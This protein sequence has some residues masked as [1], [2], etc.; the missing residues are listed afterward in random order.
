MSVRSKTN[1]EGA[2]PVGAEQDETELPDGWCRTSL[3]AIGTI[4]CGQSPATKD[5]NANGE[6][7]PYVTGPEQWDGHVIH[8]NKWTT[9]PRRIV[10]D[11][12][13]FITVKGAGVGTLF[14]GEACAIGRDVYAFH[15]TSPISRDFTQYAL[16]YT[17]DLVIRQASGLIPGLSRSH[18]LEHGI[19]LPPLAEQR[20]IVEKLG[21]VLGKVSSNQQRLSRVP[22][23]LKRFRQSV[24][25]AA[26]SGKLTADWRETNTEANNL[27][28]AFTNDVTNERYD[29]SSEVCL[30]EIPSSWRQVPVGNVSEFQQGMQIAKATR[31]KEPGPNRLPILR[32]GNYANGFTDDVDYIELDAE[33]LIAETEDVIL[34]RTGETRG[35]VLTGYRGVFHNNTFRLNFN[36]K[37][38]HRVY[39]IYWLQTEFVQGFIAK[40]S[41]RS[42]QPDLTHRAFGPCP[43]PLPPLSEQQ[44][45][46]RR[47]ERLF[48]FADQIEARLKQAQSHVDRLTQSLLAKAFRGQLVPTEH[49]LATREGRTYESATAL[50]N[51]ICE[52]GS[53]AETSTKLNGR[54]KA[55]KERRKATI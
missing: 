51:R 5:V 13:I 18:L 22:G 29:L 33:S 42:A 21:L 24:L 53:A 31:S 47:V 25:A 38:L 30:D 3:D 20:R 34:T 8:A 11:G 4:F 7:T 16:Q 40:H 26:C 54:R 28:E 9:D 23:L 17:I 2:A 41:G 39:L 14:P 35:K 45:I 19:P 1:R 49:A 50:L 32:I 10:P 27:S 43:I 46:V 48:A 6:G 55:S 37:L 44:E 36:A 15:P 12:C 52:N